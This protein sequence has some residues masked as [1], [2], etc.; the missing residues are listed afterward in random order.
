MSRSSIRPSM[1]AMVMV[2][3]MSLG[4]V[5]VL[6]WTAS[7]PLVLSLSSQ[8]RTVGNRSN[9]NSN[10]NNK[11]RNPFALNYQANSVGHEDLP[12]D[13]SMPPDDNSAQGGGP[14]TLEIIKRRYIVDESVDPA[15]TE[16]SEVFKAQRRDETTG[17]AIGDNVVIKV[18]LNHP[19]MKREA[20]AYHALQ[21]KLFVEKYEAHQPTHDRD[22][23]AIVMESGEEDLTKY[24]NNKGRRLSLKDVRSKAMRMVEV[25]LLMH[26]KNIVWCDM[27][28]CNFVV[29]KDG[30]VKGIDLESATFVGTPNYMHTASCAPP[31]YA[32]EHLEGRNMYMETTFD[33]WSLGM[34]LYHLAVGE[35]YFAPR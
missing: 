22:V 25:L 3:S 6:A 14:T 19:G 11:I 28:T 27:K 34:A 2:M 9:S 12:V 15:K 21:S 13:N 26:A 29:M 31:E 23:S 30:E 18:S 32:V 4:A 7:P 1:Y 17:K 10:R 20:E 35:H 33:I 24:I 8:K 5:T 16:K